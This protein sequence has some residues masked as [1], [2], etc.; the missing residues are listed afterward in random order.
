MTVRKFFERYRVI[1][2]T[3]DAHA[4]SLLYAV[5]LSV[6][7]PDRT[8]LLSDRGHLVRELGKILDTYA[9]AGMKHVRLAR[10]E[11]VGFEESL[12]MV[13]VSW[14]PVDDAGSA[15]LTVDTTYVLRG[16][17][18]LRICSVIPHNEE[19]CRMRMVT[20]PVQRR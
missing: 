16:G 6:V 14:E 2:E 3:G 20:A 18:Q 19:S 11:E 9:W 15:I 5:P 7:R 4:L 8:S 12:G 10:F 17:P 13:N 1:M